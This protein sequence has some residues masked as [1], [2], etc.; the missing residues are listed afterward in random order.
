MTKQHEEI[1][2]VEGLVPGDS[3]PDAAPHDH[4]SKPCND[5]FGRRLSFASWCAQMVAS[6]FRTRTSFSAF[7][8]SAIHLTRDSQISTSP[9][10][11]I[12]LPHFGVFNRMPSGLSLRQRSRI[13]FRR[14]VVLTILALNF[15]WSGNR[16]IDTVRLILKHSSQD[17]MVAVLSRAAEF[18][19]LVQFALS[20]NWFGLS[21]PLHCGSPGFAAL[22][23]SYLLGLLSGVSLSILLGFFLYHRLGHLLDFRPPAVFV[24]PAGLSSRL[25]GYLHE[26]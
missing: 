12:P 21:C 15:W 3:Q 9:A 11:P 8:R 1:S 4:A 25:Q 2:M 22:G 23:F 16:F 19:Q 14:A 17:F 5:L 6:V 7:V 13:H 26:S 20:A 10:F 18:Y 24:R